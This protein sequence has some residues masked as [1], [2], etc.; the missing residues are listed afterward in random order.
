[1]KKKSKGMKNGEKEKKKLQQFTENGRSWELNLLAH[2]GK[3]PIPKG[4]YGQK[5]GH[6]HKSRR[7]WRNVGF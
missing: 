7:G 5:S 4:L 6:E 2:T 3:A 1:V